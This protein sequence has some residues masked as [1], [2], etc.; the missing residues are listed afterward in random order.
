MQA[1]TH[2]FG[3]TYKFFNLPGIIDFP[4]GHPLVCLL[5]VQI[6]R[7]IGD[8]ILILVLINIYL[9]LSILTDNFMRNKTLKFTII[10]PC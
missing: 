7:S 9:L 10:F 1:H 5:H 6:Q 3:L 8:K 2:F 4:E